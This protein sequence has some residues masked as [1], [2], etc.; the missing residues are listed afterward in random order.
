MMIAVDADGNLRAAY[1]TEDGESLRRQLCLHYGNTGFSLDPASNPG[2][3]TAQLKRYFAGDL[4]V[5]ETIPVK[6]G[7]T[8]FQQDVWRALRDIPCGETMSYGELARQI[9]RPAAV[10]AVGAANGANPVSVVVPCH[11]VI[12][13]NGSL[14]GYGGGIERKQWL[15]HH[16]RLLLF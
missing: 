13:S 8:P 5:I 2:G 4:S 15:L 1:F 3:V 9:G 14:T 10:R 11:R 16:E 7:G 6:T 12:G